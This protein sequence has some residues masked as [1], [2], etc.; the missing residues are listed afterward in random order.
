MQAWH[1][2]YIPLVDVADTFSIFVDY[3]Y[4]ILLQMTAQIIKVI[5]FRH[6]LVD[7]NS[8]VHLR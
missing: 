5:T 6:F 1:S 4:A 3:L 8:K 7:H 2:L